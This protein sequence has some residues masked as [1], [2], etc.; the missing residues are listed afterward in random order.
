MEWT[1]WVLWVLFLNFG[2][3]WK[4]VPHSR[5]WTRDG[6][7]SPEPKSPVVTMVTSQLNPS[8]PGATVAGSSLAVQLFLSQFSLRLI[9]SA[10]SF[11]I[12]SAFVLLLAVPPSFSVTQNYFWGVSLIPCWFSWSQFFQF[13]E[14]LSAISRRR[15]PFDFHTIY[16][17]TL[18]SVSLETFCLVVLDIAVT[19][20]NPQP[21]RK[22]HSTVRELPIF[23]DAWRCCPKAIL[24][25]LTKM[26]TRSYLEF[27]V[28]RNKVVCPS[29]NFFSEFWAE[30]FTEG[31]EWYPVTR[32]S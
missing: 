17:H 32:S 13:Y 1:G 18:R 30:R 11:S 2:G 4:K 21:M 8:P 6:S 23:N 29:L 9:Q 27:K 5:I 15:D 20:L 28:A 19:W 24:L 12:F 31:V 7:A 14:P 3:L 25:M 22:N 16:V 10:C 26:V